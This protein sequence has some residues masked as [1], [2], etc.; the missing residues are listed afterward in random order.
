MSIIEELEILSKRLFVAFWKLPD[1]IWVLSLYR[2]HLKLSCFNSS[3]KVIISSDIL[4]YISMLD[5]VTKLKLWIMLSVLFIY[6]VGYRLPFITVGSPS[7]V[8]FKP[9][10]LKVTLVSTSLFHSNQAVV[11]PINSINIEHT[12]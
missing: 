6:I 5:V 4:E 3:G 9:L 10:T 7:Y 2:F 8:I 1:D 11:I 12:P